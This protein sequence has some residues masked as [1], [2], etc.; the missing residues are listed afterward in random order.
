MPGSS[1]TSRWTS[2]QTW[3]A[4]QCGHCFESSLP[5]SLRPIQGHPALRKPPAPGELFFFFLS[6]SKSGGTRRT[7]GLTIQVLGLA[8]LASIPRPAPSAACFGSPHLASGQL[9]LL[10][11]AVSSRCGRLF[12]CGSG[13]SSWAW[14]R[15]HVFVRPRVVTKQTA[16]IP[17]GRGSKPRGLFSFYWNQ[18]SLPSVLSWLMFSHFH[19]PSPIFSQRGSEKARCEWHHASGPALGTEV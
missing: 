3:Q 12:G 4:P 6:L 7:R 8:F 5:K 2:S 9:L 19:L 18:H 11:S 16:V 17:T 10:S 13:R 15:D 1:A 14:L